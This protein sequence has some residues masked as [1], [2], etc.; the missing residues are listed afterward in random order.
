[1]S[2]NGE[3]K[4]VKSE[5]FANLNSPSST[6][7]SSMKSRPPSVGSADG[8][9]RN[10]VSKENQH[11][12]QHQHTTPPATVLDTQPRLVGLSQPFFTTNPH[13]PTKEDQ[14]AAIDKAMSNRSGQGKL[15][16]LVA[17]DNS[18]NIEVVS[19]MLKLEDIY[20][21]T[22][23]KDGQ[24]A[25]DLVKATM[26][27]NERFDVIFMDIQMPNLDGLQSTRLI[28]KMGY[29]APIV[30]L[31]AFSEE[32]N[33]RECMESGMDEFLSKPIRRPALKQVLKRFATIEEEPE[34][35]SLRTPARTPEEKGDP[36]ANGH[37][38]HPDSN[39]EISPKTNGHP[40][41]GPTTGS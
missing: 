11:P 40:P 10:S 28:R 7:S 35:L 23:A 30:A 1:M 2:K 34:T 38:V 19:R 4:C 21:V 16:V 9:K 25:Y 29:S 22:I 3:F 6:A 32:S 36:L 18:T 15:R 8:E 13:T 27:N 5:T 41:P 33:V 14:M 24:E 17:D 31:T 37:A 26:E 12:L 20:D 39:G